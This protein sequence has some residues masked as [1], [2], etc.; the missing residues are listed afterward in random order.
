MDAFSSVFLVPISLNNMGAEFLSQGKI[1]ESQVIFQ[2]ALQRLKAIT[3]ALQKHPV[4]NT[5]SMKVDFHYLTRMPMQVDS[6][7]FI[8]KRPIQLME[9]KEVETYS[10]VILDVSCAVMFNLTLSFHAQGL[11]ES[12]RLSK[13]IMGYMVALKLRRF[14][15]NAFDLGLLNNIA[16]LHV[17]KISYGGAIHYFSK[18]ANLLN[19]HDNSELDAVELDGFM[20][21][22]LW[23]PPTCAGVA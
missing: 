21:G 4:R 8:F 19:R 7:T 6:E 5:K 18:V 3:I 10:V 15:R 13:A 20:S 17:E 12:Q 16:Q 2:M 11:N 23:R 1:Q 14:R 22:V 9:T